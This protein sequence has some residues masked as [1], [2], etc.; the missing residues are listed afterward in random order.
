MSYR[1]DFWV[2]KGFL[3]IWAYKLLNIYCFIGLK[4]EFI[5]FARKLFSFF[6]K[7][8]FFGPIR[9]LIIYFYRLNS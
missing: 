4:T 1:F 2:L 7:K 3:Y 8:A 5:T 6:Y 9:I